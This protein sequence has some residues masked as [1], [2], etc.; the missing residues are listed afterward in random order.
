[1]SIHD[2]FPDS[3]VGHSAGRRIS[4]HEHHVIA[5]PDIGATQLH[6]F[7]HGSGN[8]IHLMPAVNVDFVELNNPPC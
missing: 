3:E 2:V 7:S 4:H 1:M 8:T 5:G 6:H